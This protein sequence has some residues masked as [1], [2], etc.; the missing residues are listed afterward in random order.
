[1]RTA[2][3][4]AGALLLAGC[5]DGGAGEI[6]CQQRMVDRLSGPSPRSGPGDIAGPFLAL[7]Q[8]VATMPRDG[9]SEDQVRTAQSIAASAG[10]VAA[11]ARRAGDIMKAIDE[12]RSPAHDPNFAMLMDELEGFERRRD[13]LRAELARMTKGER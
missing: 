8:R 13:A 4:L 2:A 1:M 7:R 9:C 11:A 3:L 5:G 12:S 6:A 10:R